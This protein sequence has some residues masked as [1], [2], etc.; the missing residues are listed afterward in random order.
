M[1]AARYDAIAARYQLEVGDNLHDP[2]TAAL[3]AMLPLVSDLRVLDIAC[4]QGRVSR[5]LARRG[6]IVRGADVSEAMLATA[7]R[8]EAEQPLGIEYAC[9]DIA[10][11][12]ALVGESFDGVVCNFGL[13]DINNLDGAVSTVS[14]CLAPNGWF[15]FSILHPCFPG[16]DPDAPTSWSRSG[17]YHEGWWLAD[18][19][20]FRGQVGANHR[21]LSTYV[22]TLIQHGLELELMR[23][24]EPGAAWARRAPNKSPVPVYLVALCRRVGNA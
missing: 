15:A 5:E 3:L 8:L 12:A 4:G 14:R 22:N 10:D 6:A 19:L 24:P 11:P 9:V 7:R 17:Y 18:N 21:M 2:P 16:W 13:G 1:R 23:E 20:G